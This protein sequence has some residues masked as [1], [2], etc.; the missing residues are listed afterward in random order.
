MHY[1]GAHSVLHG[2][3]G[4]ASAARAAEWLR[5]QCKPGRYSTA[6]FDAAAVRVQ[7][8]DQ[9]IMDKFPTALRR[10]LLH[11]L[12]LP[13]I[14][15]KYLLQGMSSNRFIDALLAS[16]DVDLYMPGVDLVEQNSYVSELMLL[17]KGTV[18]VR[19]PTWCDVFTLRGMEPF[20]TL[21]AWP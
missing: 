12:Y 3:M 14:E 9:D 8:R 16:A 13:H 19:T 21:S 5:Y 10:R 17:V 7:L 20:P 2:C 1:Y 11:T 4:A 6:R 18:Q 15:D